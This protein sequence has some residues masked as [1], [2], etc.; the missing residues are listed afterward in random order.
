MGK[1]GFLVPARNPQALAEAMLHLHQHPTL[2]KEMGFAG[3]QQVEREFSIEKMV[4][5]YEQQYVDEV[6]P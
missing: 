4:R 1:P 5:K 3:R 2:G 6:K